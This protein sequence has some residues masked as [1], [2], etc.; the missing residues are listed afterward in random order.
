[1]KE[2]GINGVLW[3]EVSG[4]WWAPQGTIVTGSEEWQSAMQWAIS[5]ADRLSMEFGLSIDCGYGSGGTHITPDISMQ[6]LVWS[7]TRVEGG[8]RVSI[9]LPRPELDYREALQAPGFDPGNLSI[10]KC[11]RI[12]MKLIPTGTWLYLPS[13]DQK[14]IVH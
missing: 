12:L 8:D 5:E 6:N 11:L 4:P 14:R 1:M 10:R 7:E 9:E 13:L 2:N 3:M